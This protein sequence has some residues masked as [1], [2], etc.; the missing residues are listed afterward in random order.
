MKLESAC[1]VH[2]S[3]PVRLIKSIQIQITPRPIQLIAGIFFFFLRLL[4]V[5]TFILLHIK[6]RPTAATCKH[7]TEYTTIR[8][9]HFVDQGRDIVIAF[10]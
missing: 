5:D 9:T 3:N 2:S 7:C 4:S 6:K 10:Q 1:A 8:C